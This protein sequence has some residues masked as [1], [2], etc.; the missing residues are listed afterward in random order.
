MSLKSKAFDYIE[1]PGNG[2]FKVIKVVTLEE[3][4][5]LEIDNEFVRQANRDLNGANLRMM[6]QIDDINEIIDPHIKQQERT[7]VP[8][9]YEIT[10]DCKEIKR[11][12]EVLSLSDEGV[13][14][15]EG[16][17][18]KDEDCISFP[19]EYAAKD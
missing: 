9:D 7:R 18:R 1:S 13:C 15:E 16:C 6:K 12:R 14:I 19:L 5:K 17:S 2:T 4:Q 3:A 11:L 10:L 8:I